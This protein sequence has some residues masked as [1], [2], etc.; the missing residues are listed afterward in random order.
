MADLISVFIFLAFF[1]LVLVRRVIDVYMFA[2]CGIFFYYGGMLL[3]GYTLD[4][5]E[6]GRLVLNSKQE[7]S[8]QLIMY[9]FG[10]LFLLCYFSFIDYFFKGGS[11][12]RSLI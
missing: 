5:N 7:V 1:Y 9:I 3:L 11:V 2:A 10:T 6:A 4:V 12:S 8:R